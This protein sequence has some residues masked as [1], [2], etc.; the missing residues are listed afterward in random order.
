MIRSATIDDLD[1]LVQ[2][3]QACF[4]A[5]RWSRNSWRQEFSGS[6]QIHIAQAD[7][8]SI[9]FVV[10]MRAGDDAEL[11]RIAVLPQYQREGVA[12]GLMAH[13]LSEA[14]SSGAAAMFLEVDSGNERALALYES[15]GFT[16][17]SRRSDYYGTGRD[18]LILTRSLLEVSV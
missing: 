18:A 12:R 1:A 13:A 9:G 8:Q 14:A 15:A 16:Q 7:H 4:A 2:I 5:D 10:V 17:L 3:E 11:L 6:R